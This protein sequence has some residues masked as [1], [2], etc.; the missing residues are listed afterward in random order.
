MDATSALA[1]A[2]ALTV[3][4]NMTASKLGVDHYEAHKKHPDRSL[5]V[6]DLGHMILPQMKTSTLIDVLS[7]YA[8]IPFLLAAPEDVA[9]AVQSDIGMRLAFMFIVR[10]VTTLVTIL[11]KNKDCDS[12]KWTWH[13]LLGGACYDKIFSGHTAIATL[14]S[15]A[16][17]KH[18]IWSVAVGWMYALGIAFLV[19]VSR[20]H[21]TVDVVLGGVLAVLTWSSTIFM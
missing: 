7:G 13:E 2:G 20:G 6:F 21:Y 9:A 10:S 3:A 1:V 14:V 5:E 12:S 19:L 18:G 8:W 15:L 4:S 11:P 17:V 16:F